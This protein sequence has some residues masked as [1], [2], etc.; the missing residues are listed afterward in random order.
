V[1]DFNTL[2]I[3]IYRSS[4]QKINKESQT[5]NDTLYQIDLIDIYRT[6]HLK[7]S[8]HNFFSNAHV[9]HMCMCISWRTQ[10]KLYLGPKIE[11]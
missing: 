4:K 6:F 7:S 8:E 5:L 9:M 2:L 1:E 3:P 11:P 10:D